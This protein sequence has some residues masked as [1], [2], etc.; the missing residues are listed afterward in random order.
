M[1]TIF[2]A[3]RADPYNV[4]GTLPGWLRRHFMAKAIGQKANAP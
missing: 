2:I 4:S 1:H 3:G